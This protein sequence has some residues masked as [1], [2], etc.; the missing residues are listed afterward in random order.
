MMRTGVLCAIG[1]TPLVR[2]ETAGPARVFAKLEYTNPG[3]SVKDRVALFMIEYAEREGLLRPGGT[4]VEASSGNQGIALAMI[5]AVK[6][7]SV[8]I[9]TADT[10]SIE[11]IDT[12]RAYGADV[13]LCAPTLSSHDPQNYRNI[14]R[15][16]HHETPGSFMPDQFH[17]LCNPLAHYAWLGPE[18]WGQTKGKITHLF[19]SAGSGGT[20]SG[21]G[22]FLKERSPNILIHAVDAEGSF[23]ATK[24]KPR[25]YALDGMGLDA[26]WPTIDTSVIDEMINISDDVGFMMMRRIAREYGILVGPSSGAVMAAVH[27]RRDSFIPGDTVVMIFGD[28]GRA[29]MS[30]GYFG[31]QD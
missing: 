20:V 9:T 7:Y 27:Q 5:G 4:I 6:G 17:N 21:A 23:Y 12:M 8:I 16:I 1:N 11:K 15:N 3:G 2:L 30:K 26:E 29:Y 13:R 18:I 24:G 31:R 19:A 22:R 14:A 10:T 28:S 25:P